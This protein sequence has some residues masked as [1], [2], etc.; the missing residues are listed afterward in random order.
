MS[1]LFPQTAGIVDELCFVR[2][3][4]TE[5]INHDPAVMFF[6]TGSQ[7]PGRP[8]IGAWLSYGLGS[9]N[10][11]LPSFVVLVTKGKNGQPLYARLWGNGFLPSEHQGVQFRPGRDAVLYL[12]NPPGVTADARREQIEHLREALELQYDAFAD[13][14]IKGADCPVRDGLPHAVVGSRSDEHRGTSRSTFLICTARDAREA[15]GRMPPI[16]CWLGGSRNAASNSS[17]STIAAGI[18]TATCRAM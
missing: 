1:E 4:F 12:S 17:S 8:S 7:F 2:S 18:S 15:G 14:E 5:A 10:D 13:P 9:L 3:M 11:N 16:V 6:Q